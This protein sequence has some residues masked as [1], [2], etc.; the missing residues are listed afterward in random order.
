MTV[1][2]IKAHDWA[3]AADE[4]CLLCNGHGVSDRGACCPRCVGSGKE[5]LIRP[6]QKDALAEARAEMRAGRSC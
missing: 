5:P 4:L 2:A 3:G 6:W 1:D